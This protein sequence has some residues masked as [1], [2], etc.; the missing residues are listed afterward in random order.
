MRLGA[1]ELHSLKIILLYPRIGNTSIEVGQNSSLIG[2]ARPQTWQSY[3]PDYGPGVEKA[4]D[5]LPVYTT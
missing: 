5:L 3:S 1:A 2:H 4:N